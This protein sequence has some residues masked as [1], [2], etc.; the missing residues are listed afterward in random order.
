NQI[1]MDQN[2]KSFLIGVSISI[3]KNTVR[4]NARRQ[5]IAPTI[6]LDE[7]NFASVTSEMSVEDWTLS[8]H[9]QDEVRL[10]IQRMEDKFRLPILLYYTEELPIEKVAKLLHL[11]RGTVKSRLYKARLLIKNELEG[12][13]YDTYR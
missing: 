11:P 3:W 1:H 13:G 2:P 5:R 12:K 10:I 8:S 6:S 7:E 9:L 4:K